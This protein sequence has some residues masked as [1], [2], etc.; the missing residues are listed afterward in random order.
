MNLA[1]LTTEF[2]YPEAVVT[3]S[4]HHIT[5]LILDRNPVLSQCVSSSLSAFQSL[6]CKAVLFDATSPPVISLDTGADVL[7][8]DPAQI[9]RPLDT[10][11]AD[12]G[13]MG[14]LHTVAY[15]FDTSDATVNRVLDAGVDCYASKE[16]D[17]LV[18]YLAIATAAR[19]GQFLCPTIAK[20]FH[21]VRDAAA[22]AKVAEAAP[23][24]V[25]STRE[26]SVLSA[27]ASGLSQ[28]QTAFKLDLSDKTISTYKS[29]AMR[30]LGL[31]DRAS[32]VQF[33]I[34]QNLIAPGVSTG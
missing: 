11:L 5:A 22:P 31:T 25:L 29:R 8:F 24:A 6:D 17:L 32:I 13:D 9:G 7:V 30:K 10:Y 27:L 15:S 26:L 3:P 16:Q 18:L 33:A 34:E 14:H 21:R 12:L 20:G 28:K 23:K 2:S 4:A 1:G 19:G